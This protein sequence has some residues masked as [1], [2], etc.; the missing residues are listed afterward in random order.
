GERG[1]LRSDPSL[2]TGPLASSWERVLKRLPLSRWLGREAARSESEPRAKKTAR[3]KPGG[4]G[5][6]GREDLLGRGRSGT[7]V[8]GAAVGGG[9]RAGA[10]RRAAATLPAVVV[11]RGGR[12]HLIRA[13]AKECRT[14]ALAADGVERRSRGREHRHENRR[15]QSDSDNL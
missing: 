7:G 13:G 14:A 2:R 8:D 4:G 3:P 6:L 15:H 5:R 12:G 11:A 9:A 1:F 10:G